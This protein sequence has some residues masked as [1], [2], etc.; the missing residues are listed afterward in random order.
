MKTRCIATSFCLLS[1]PFSVFAETF[2]MKDGSTLEGVILRED[3]TSY[4]VEVKVTKSIKDE[5]TIAKADVEKIKRDQ[6]DLAAF[7]EI[8]KLV[9]TP[10]FLTSEEYGRKIRAVEKFL[11]VHIGS[12][13]SKEAKAILA[14]I[15]S[16]ANE[17]LAGG[18]KMNGKIVPPAEYRA[19]MY[20]IDARIQE[21]KIRNLV[22]G[23]QLL[24]ALRAF[25]DFGVDF[26]NTSSHAALL[27]L[28]QQVINSYLAETGQSLASFDARIKEREVG[29]QRMP[30]SDRQ[31]TERAIREENE[32]LEARLKKEKDAKLGWVTT[33]PFFKPSLDETMN[34]GKQ[35]LSRITAM[36]TAT[37]VDGGKIFRDALSSLQGK[38]DATAATA[39]ISSARAAMIPQKY[40][41]ILEA[42]APAGR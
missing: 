17:V 7:E 4:V 33:H 16:E 41:D 38:A 42:A 34:F 3:T 25:K 19:N 30:A 2:V 20:D 28:M 12:S 35:E 36:K 14:T 39:A 22:N 11:K 26:R 40:I 18:I 1:F 9:P 27:P 13:K 24:P 21:A 29:L 6:P 23:G 15:K 5:R 10:D 32:A 37:A 8:A 31:S